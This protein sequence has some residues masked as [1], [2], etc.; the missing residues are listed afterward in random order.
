M[1][2][3]EH[4]AWWRLCIFAKANAGKDQVSTL[5]KRM[6]TQGTQIGAASIPAGVVELVPVLYP[7]RPDTV[8]GFRELR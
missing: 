3:E 1:P 2:S 4:P 7:E 6:P 8:T 5:R